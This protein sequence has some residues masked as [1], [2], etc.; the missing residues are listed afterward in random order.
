MVECALHCLYNYNLTHMYSCHQWKYVDSNELKDILSERVDEGFTFPMNPAWILTNPNFKELY[1]KL[2]ASDKPNVRES[3]KVWYPKDIQQR[4]HQIS[5]KYPEGFVSYTKPSRDRMSGNSCDLAQ[6]EL[7]RYNVR[8][9]GQSKL[10]RALTRQRLKKNKTPTLFSTSLMMLQFGKESEV[11]ESR[12]LS[13][14]ADN[15]CED[16]QEVKA[17]PQDVDKKMPRRSSKSLASSNKGSKRRSF[18]EARRASLDRLVK[19]IKRALSSRK[20]KSQP[21]IN[22]K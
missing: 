5:S 3:I 17:V 14:I 10:R 22:T 15:D 20:S 2:I 13:M 6:M 4:M 19:P 12:Q 16:D 1:D 11:Q 8:R 18:A 7:K 21:D 9:K